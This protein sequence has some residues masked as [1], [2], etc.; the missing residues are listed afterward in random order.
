LD[1]VEEV[2]ATNPTQKSLRLFGSTFAAEP[3]GDWDLVSTADTILE[4]AGARQRWRRGICGRSSR[5]FLEEDEEVWRQLWPLVCQE[6]KVGLSVGVRD[7]V[8]PRVPIQ[9]RASSAIDQDVEEL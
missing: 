3:C 7:Y 6:D 9:A 1:K 2:A 8:S 4:L 5:R